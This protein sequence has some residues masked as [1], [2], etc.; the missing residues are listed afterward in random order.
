MPINQPLV[1]RKANIILKDL[2]AIKDFAG[3]TP[4]I[5]LSNYTQALAV[6]RL[7][8]KIIGRLIDINFHLLSESTHQLPKDY[9]TSFLEMG[10]S[11]FVKPDLANQLAP[12][13]AMRNILAHE[14]DEIDPD[15]ICQ[16]IGKIIHLAPQYLKQILDKIQT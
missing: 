1:I 14:Y 9:F 6:E 13:S 12:S 2:E 8:E 5:Y 11:G 16:S 3:L 15:L 4:E 7:L 10:K